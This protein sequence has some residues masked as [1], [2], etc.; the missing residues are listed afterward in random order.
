[1]RRNGAN[2]VM[3]VLLERVERYVGSFTSVMLLVYVTLWSAIRE[4]CFRHLGSSSTDFHIE[5]ICHFIHELSHDVVRISYL[6]PRD[7]YNSRGVST[8]T[9]V[10]IWHS[11]TDSLRPRNEFYL[12]K[13]LCQ[14]PWFDKTQIT[15]LHP[16]SNSMLERFNRTN[17]N[18]LSHMAW[19]NQPD[20]G[21][22]L[23]LSLLAYCSTAYWTTSYTPSKMLF[24]RELRLPFDRFFG[25]KKL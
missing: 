20:W 13:G 2:L 19:K 5:R 12:F 23:R 9:C 21:D 3:S 16:Q 8:T 15:P 22:K 14:F 18:N 25:L 4:D 6:L 10:N 11:I 17:L 7:F 1:M 24:G